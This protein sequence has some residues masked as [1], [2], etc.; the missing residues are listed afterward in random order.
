MAAGRDNSIDISEVVALPVM[1][2]NE[3]AGE[4]KGMGTSKYHDIE[5]CEW[6][7]G[8]DTLLER[9]KQDRE[10]ITYLV[11]ND[12]EK[13]VQTMWRAEGPLAIDNECL[14]Q[15]G[16]GENRSP[17][18]CAQ[19]KNLRRLIDFRL[20]GVERPFKIECGKDAGK[21]LIV[22][23]SEINS[24]F[25]NWD[26]DSA[27]KAKGYVQQY[28]NLT[29]CGTPEINGMRCITGDT[30]TTR[31]II[32][33]MIHKLF[34]E[35][36]L[37]HVPTMHTAFVCRGIGYSLYDMPTIGTLA[38]LHSIEDYHE[39]S[40]SMKTSHHGNVV[41]PRF[42]YSSSGDLQ[43][44]REY[45][46]GGLIHLTEFTPTTQSDPRSQHSALAPLKSSVAR[47]I[48]VQLLVT[49]LELSKVN[50]SHGTP[51][52]HGLI[53][54]KDA[55]SYAYDGVH[56]EGP[57]TLQISDLWNSSATFNNVHYFPKNVKSSMY[58]ERGM[59]VPEISTKTV[60][61]AHCH[62]S[63]IT[64]FNSDVNDPIVCPTT[65]NTCPD[66]TSYSV[67]KPK[68]TT[69]YR[70]TNSTLDIYNAMRHIGFPLYVGSF[71]FYCFMV[72]L[73]CDRAFYSAVAHDDRL[74]R[75]WSMMWLIEDLPNVERMIKDVHDAEVIGTNPRADSNTVINIIRGSWLRCDIIKY[76]W[77][78]IK[79]GW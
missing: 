79:L 25:I 23:S 77:S 36:G 18:A 30:F 5:C 41:N 38:S 20:G 16:R 43:S 53:F 66:A 13:L 68:S 32:L 54:N 59:F 15:M 70:L 40:S 26:E 1:G 57:I 21:D 42:N 34:S 47:T 74:Y 37:P 58:L 14:C 17:F 46:E 27:R 22:A 6:T 55:V 19:C 35:Q 72:S 62:D 7:R 78:L 48:I 39:I 28:H 10:E 64:S 60:S 61:M 52:I 11:L 49:L 73:M 75:L 4:N 71:D 24:P 3:V 56:V 33:W 63:G 9:Y 44:E 31:T 69:L 2:N 29:I 8:I 45:D 50:F 76:V 65:V 51:S 67:C 12:P